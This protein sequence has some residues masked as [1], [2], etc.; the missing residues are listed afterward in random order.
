[1]RSYEERFVS[2][3]ENEY[4]EPVLSIYEIT[5][6]SLFTKFLI[7]ENKSSK[8]VTCEECLDTWSNSYEYL[9][10]YFD[11]VILSWMLEN[12]SDFKLFSE[13]GLHV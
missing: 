5:K 9:S 2:S 7:N 10:K 11:D 4:E 13:I 6:R 8:N 1:M 12:E 3:F